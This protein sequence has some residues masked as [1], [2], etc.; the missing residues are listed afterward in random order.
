[1]EREEQ[2]KGNREQ[3]AEPNWSQSLCKRKGKEML[4]GGKKNKEKSRCVTYK[5]KFLIMYMSTC[6]MICINKNNIAKY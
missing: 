1:M 2:E 5:Y 4:K 3:M 6:M